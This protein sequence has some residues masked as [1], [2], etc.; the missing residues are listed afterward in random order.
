MSRSARAAPAGLAA[1]LAVLAAVDPAVPASTA[2]RDALVV[3]DVTRS[4]NTRDMAGTSRFEA[5][6][7]GLRDWIGQQ[8]CG[9]RIGLGIFTER[10]SLTLFDPVEVCADFPSLSGTLS[11]LDWRMAWEGDSMIS[12]GLNHAM[13]RAETLD[14]ALVFVTDGQEAPPLPYSGPEPYDGT[15]PAGVIVGAGGD[16]PAPIPKFDEYGRET[17]FYDSGDVQHAPARR[18]P[19]PPDAASRPGYH[20]RN[21]PYG[22]ADLEGTEHLSALRA[23]YLQELARTCGLGFVRLSDGPEALDAAM[24]EWVPARRQDAPRG[25]APVFG[26][27]ALLALLSGWLPATVTTRLRD[28][29]HH[30]RKGDPK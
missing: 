4:M 5:M 17:G 11:A 15:C 25:L 29:A 2:L 22:E 14:V 6:R 7:E 23:D 16:G 8:P 24:S 30:R 10:R 3:V 19:P 12:K 13:A 1:G 20:P 21:N 18:G 9:T 28:I 26:T 27:L